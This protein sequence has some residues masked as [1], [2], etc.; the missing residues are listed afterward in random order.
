MWVLPPMK[1]AAYATWFYSGLCFLNFYLYEQFWELCAVWDQL[2]CLF[3]AR[4]LQCERLVKT[5]SYKLWKNCEPRHKLRQTTYLPTLECDLTLTAISYGNNFFR[6]ITSFAFTADPLRPGSELHLHF[7]PS[8]S[9]ELSL[10]AAISL[11][12]SFETYISTHL[13][14]VSNWLCVFPQPWEAA[15][16]PPIDAALYV[17]SHAVLM[18]S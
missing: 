3:A 9:T 5:G 7:P 2:F 15:A 17:T 10:L 4:V 14:G 1:C 16:F 8:K 18:W 13:R 12:T 11:F 6:T